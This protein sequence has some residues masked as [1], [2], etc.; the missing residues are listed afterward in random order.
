MPHD[1]TGGRRP[2]PKARGMQGKAAG[3]PLSQLLHEAIKSFAGGK[4]A[5]IDIFPSRSTSSLMGCLVSIA[6]PM[7][8][9]VFILSCIQT[10]SGERLRAGLP[11]S[12]PR[13]DPV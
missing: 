2:S 4:A 6:L 10:G 11:R 1:N 5:Y 13:A 12:S 3:L 8:P 9:G 7:L